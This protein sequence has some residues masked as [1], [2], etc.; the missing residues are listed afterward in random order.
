MA[1]F[2]SDGIK[3]YS[4]SYTDRKKLFPIHHSRGCVYYQIPY[5]HKFVVRENTLR[6]VD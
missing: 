1:V 2:C 5:Q 4:T 6:Q 3:Y